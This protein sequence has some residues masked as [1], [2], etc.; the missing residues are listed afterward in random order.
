MW[1]FLCVEAATISIIIIT[2][3]HKTEFQ[4]RRQRNIFI[5]SENYQIIKACLGQH[6]VNKYAGN[7]YCYCFTI[8]GVFFHGEKLLEESISREVW[9]HIRSKEI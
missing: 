8:P 6:Y 7:Y 5:S 3:F 1:I 4:K 2:E 9:F